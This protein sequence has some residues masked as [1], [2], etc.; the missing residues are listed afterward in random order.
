MPKLFTLFRDHERH[1]TVQTSQV[2]DLTVEFGGQRILDNITLQ[3]CSGE[4]TALIGPNGAGKSTLLKC[5]LGEV[6]YSGK[7]KFLDAEGNPL[8]RPRIGYVPQR[9]S[10]DADSPVSV[11]DLFVASHTRYPAWLHLPLGVRQPVEAILT[12]VGAERLI[13]QRLGALSGGEL[14]RVL[15]AL[16]LTPLPDLLLLDEPVSGVDQNGMQLFYQTLAEL[17]RKQPA[18]LLVSHDLDPVARISDQIILLNRR[19]LLA[20]TPA[21]VLDDHRFLEVFGTSWRNAQPVQA[22]G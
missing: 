8:P 18:I 14:Q 22:I 20:G 12:T 16:A 17:K 19:V 9:L 10:I 21:E 3:I 13:D 7:L 4:L 15:L 11:L 6:G 2:A 1:S 5:L